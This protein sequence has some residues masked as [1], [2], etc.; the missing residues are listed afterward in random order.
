MATPEEEG[1]VKR[2][3][4]E[5]GFGFIARP[6]GP[7]LFFHSRNCECSRLYDGETV[8]FEIA[9]NKDG[10]DEARAVRRQGGD[11]ATGD[12]LEWSVDPGTWRG[13]GLIAPH[14][15]GDP[16][17]FSGEDLMRSTPGSRQTNPR[18]WHA[19]RYRTIPHGVTL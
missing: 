15:G 8:S 5:K 18:P 2:Y 1:T 19:A 13:E 6:G 17:R 4:E 12:V 11:F 9:K 3:L 7:D 14:G 10:R 16:I